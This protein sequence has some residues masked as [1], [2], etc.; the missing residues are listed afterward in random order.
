MKRAPASELDRLQYNEQA[1][2]VDKPEEKTVLPVKNGQSLRLKADIDVASA[3]QVTF[4]VCED[5]AANAHT[6]II[7]DLTNNQLIV[8][9]T[10]SGKEGRLTKEIAPFE[11][12]KNEKLSLDIFVDHSVIEVFA[13]ERQ[14]ICRR[15]YP[16]NPSVATQIST[17]SDGAKYNKVTAWEMMPTN[18][19]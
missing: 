13:N 16:T 10:C 2:V 18:A 7:V 5:T 9:T 6:D 17:Y 19:Y 3:T 12:S 1:L 4:T 15:I 14:A 8:D 11:L